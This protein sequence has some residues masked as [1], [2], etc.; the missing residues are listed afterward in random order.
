MR[1]SKHQS[2]DFIQEDRAGRLIEVVAA[3]FLLRVDFA[4]VFP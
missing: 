3:S 2:G 4:E 1:T